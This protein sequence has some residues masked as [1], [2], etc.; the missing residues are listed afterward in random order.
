M[1]QRELKKVQKSNFVQLSLKKDQ[2]LESDDVKGFEFDSEKN[3]NRRFV[4]L[5]NS[6]YDLQMK[7]FAESICNIKQDVKLNNFYIQFDPTEKLKP[8]VL[9][10]EQYQEFISY[11]DPSNS[12]CVYD[13]FQ[14]KVH[15]YYNSGPTEKKKVIKSKEQFQVGKKIEVTYDYCHHCKQRKPEECMLKCK[16]IKLSVPKAREQI[17]IYNINGT[18]IVKRKLF[19]FI[20]Q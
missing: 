9:N 14:E 6:V 15:S 10:K 5:M 3:K 1:L 16:S 8:I 20:I 17:K 11:R 18:T 7:Q 4:N 19:Y 2:I 13:L 12:V